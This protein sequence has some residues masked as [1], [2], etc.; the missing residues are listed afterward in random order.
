M[1]ADIAT[2]LSQYCFP[3]VACVVMAWYVKYT[4]DRNR[5]DLLAIRKEHEQ[6]TDKLAEALNNNTVAL[7]QIV[8]LLGEHYEKNN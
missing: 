1:S 3:I 6:E 2:L 5:E 8:T 4:G 7:T